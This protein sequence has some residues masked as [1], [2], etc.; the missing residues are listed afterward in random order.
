[1]VILILINELEIDVDGLTNDSSM[2]TSD[3]FWLRTETREDF[4]EIKK[5]VWG[6]NTVKRISLRVNLGRLKMCGE[7][8]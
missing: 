5:F 6:E 8:I 1:M 2:V 7:I 4:C 3:G